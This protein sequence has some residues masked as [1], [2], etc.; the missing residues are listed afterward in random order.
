MDRKNIIDA[1]IHQENSDYHFVEG[2]Y[3]SIQF[4]I[5]AFTFFLKAL[6]SFYIQSYVSFLILTL[7]AVV[8][9]IAK[10]GITISPSLQQYRYFFG[11]LKFKFGNW[12]TLPEFES[13]SI[14]RARKSQT[15]TIATQSSTAYFSEIEVNLIY[16]TSRKLTVYITNNYDVAIEKARFFEGLFKLSIYDATEREGKWL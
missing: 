16:N 5:L 1:P 3:F 11:L 14:F 10:K 8:I 6:H 13:I 15:N 2:S 12:Q 9:F 7:L 4:K